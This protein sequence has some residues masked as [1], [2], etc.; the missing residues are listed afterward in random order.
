MSDS[1][2]SPNGLFNDMLVMGLTDTDCL[3]EGAFENPLDHKAPEIEIHLN[4]ESERPTIVFDDSGPGM[5]KATLLLSRRLFNRKEASDDKN[6]CFGIGGSIASAQLTRLAGEATRLTKMANSKKLLQLT[7][8]YP[9]ITSQDK[10]NP[11]VHEA[12]AD[13]SEFWKANAINKDHGTME[14]LECPKSVIEDLIRDISTANFERMYA[15]YLTEGTK[16]RIFVNGTLHLDLKPKCVSDEKNA[17]RCE[18]YDVI[19]W[20]KLN[21][22]SPSLKDAK[23]VLVQFKNGH[24]KMVFVDPVTEKQIEDDPATKGFTKIAPINC[25][26]SI[27]YKKGAADNWKAEDGGYFPKR[28]RKI[29]D[30]FAI[31]RPSGGDYAGQDI[32]TASRH[33]WKYSTV[34]DPLLGT[35][36]NKSRI[37]VS[38]IRPEIY[39][40]LVDLARKFSN[41]YYKDIKPAE[42]KTIFQSI[43]EEVMPTATTSSSNARPS[44]EVTPSTP[45]QKKSPLSPAKVA[46]VPE[47]ILMNQAPKVVVT[48]EAKQTVVDVPAHQKLVPQS[49]YD[50]VM[51]VMDFNKR[52]QS[53]KLDGLL[54]KATITSEGGISK[55]VS[56]LNE[57]LKV[58]EQIK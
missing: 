45:V 4:S 39:A 34:L 22:D 49:Q 58:L 25:V 10:Y 24:G 54:K 23:E 29:I 56:T 16:I 50:L 13:W 14:I 51:A 35:E 41:K 28:V 57:A 53:L 42:P 8:N 40:V 31:P 11:T 1:S 7:L 2:I 55:I 43:Q 9:E 33:V 20:A 21:S 52:T 46:A 17:S 38:N 48:P 6:G 5:E 36:I 19:V 32:I 18:K 44:L 15:D 30:R 26:S 12:T 27:R 37:N 47:N 3:R